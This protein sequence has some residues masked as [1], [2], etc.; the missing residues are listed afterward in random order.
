MIELAP[1]HKI[2][3]PV[4][5]PVLLAGG[6]IGYGEACHAGLELGKLGGVVVGPVMRHSTA[7]STPPRY[8]TV[9]G[10]MVLESGLQNRGVG[11]VLRRFGRSWSGLGCPVI[12][13]IADSQSELLGQV[14]RRI[15]ET[16]GV[17]GIELLL[18]HHADA[19]LTQQLLRT[20]VRAGDLPVWAKLPLDRAAELAEA[21]IAGGASALVIGSPPPGATLRERGDGTRRAIVGGLYGPSAFA[22]ML[23]SLLR[24]AEMDLPGALIACGGIHTLEQARQALAAGAAAL[25]IDSAVWIEPGL[26]ARLAEELQHLGIW[27]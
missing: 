2:G 16:I 18:P 10:G 8:G 4:E 17:S 21:A 25:Q 5:N 6:A 15:H 14:A 27:P 19:S 12:V 11:A 1:H 23:A 13:Q 26:P 24:L 9:D 20:T 3:L 7:G 22:P